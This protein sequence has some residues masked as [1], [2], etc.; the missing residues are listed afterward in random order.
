MGILARLFGCQGTVRFEGVTDDGV[1]FSGKTKIECIGFDNKELEAELKK[2]LFVET[3][4]RIK[5]LHI[6]AA[7]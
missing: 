7:T 2:I 6:I 1:K 3:G 4:R 5:E